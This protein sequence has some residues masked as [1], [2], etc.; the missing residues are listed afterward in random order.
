[1]ET[2]LLAHASA[3]A[4]SLSLRQVEYSLTAW[5]HELGCRHVF[6]AL[7]MALCMPC[8]Q[9]R[10]AKNHQTK[11]KGHCRHQ[12]ASICSLSAVSGPAQALEL[13]LC[14]DPSLPADRVPRPA[15]T[16]SEAH[17]PG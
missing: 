12:D 3:N 13:V 8:M 6:L 7:A 14:T 1:M 5:T 4:A 17:M 9:E 11:P 10:V 2:S 16:V 15:P